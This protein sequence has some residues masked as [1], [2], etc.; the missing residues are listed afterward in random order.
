MLLIATWGSCM[1]FFSNIFSPFDIILSGDHLDLAARSNTILLSNHQLYTDW[2]YIWIMARYLNKH[3]LIRIILKHDLQ[4]HFPAGWACKLFEFIFVKRKWSFDRN[5]LLSAFAKIKQLNLPFWLIL[6]PEGTLVCDETKERSDKFATKQGWPIDL[7]NVLYPK[8]TGTYYACKHLR[9]KS[10]IDTGIDTIFDLTVAYS[11]VPLSKYAYDVYTPT[12]I[13]VDGLGP[14]KVFIHVD[15]VP[16][17]AVP[18]LED[19]ADAVEMDDTASDKN[20]HTASKNEE[21]FGQWLRD[22]Y[23]QKDQLMDAF[24]QNGSFIPIEPASLSE[25]EIYETQYGMKKEYVI[26][27]VPKWDDYFSVGLMLLVTYSAWKVVF[28]IMC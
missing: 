20:I 8:T 14:R 22:R 17:D 1:V 18:G 10:Q 25:R 26:H 6:F 2:W 15:K 9:K 11:D 19:N 28:Y 16:L 5:V 23:H 4:F 27:V 7:K 21:I 3:S 24:L 12:R 13:F